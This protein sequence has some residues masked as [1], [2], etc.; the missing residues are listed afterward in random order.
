MSREYLHTR[1]PAPEADLVIVDES[2]TIE[3]VEMDVLPINM[4]SPDLVARAADGL[5]SISTKRDMMERLHKALTASNA[6][7]ALRAEGI[8]RAE[9]RALREAIDS[10]PGV[11]IDGT[12]D[13][14][15]IEATLDE[16]DLRDRQR[17]VL[18]LRALEREIDVP[19][20][21]LN[22]VTYDRRRRCVAVSFLRPPVAALNAP[23]LVLD[24]TGDPQLNR[25]LF[26]DALVHEEV[27][28][29]RKATVTGTMGKGYSRQS[30]TGHDRGGNPLNSREADASRLRVEIGH[31][32]RQ[33]R[34][35]VK[36]PS[37]RQLLRPSHAIAKLHRP[38]SLFMRLAPSALQQE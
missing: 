31:V 28:I 4:L 24:G 19:R 32:V 6:L 29:E 27:R 8:G 22:A 26:G 7:A 12:M 5:R 30:I 25:A 38:M 15:D 11:R 9:L 2:A 33:T 3:A 1:C 21:V 10:S 13:D 35:V 14:S 34:S 16:T 36:S 18:L 37:P 17:V 20:D 23:V